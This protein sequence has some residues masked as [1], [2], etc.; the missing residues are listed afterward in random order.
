[1]IDAR[2]KDITAA[3]NRMLDSL[4]VDK[5]YEV[6]S[7]LCVRPTILTRHSSV[8][9]KLTRD[10]RYKATGDMF[11]AL[12]CHPPPGALRRML[13]IA[14]AQID[15]FIADRRDRREGNEDE[16]EDERP[17]DE[18]AY[19][20]QLD[21]DENQIMGQMRATFKY[22]NR[23]TLD[24]ESHEFIESVLFAIESTVGMSPEIMELEQDTE[25]EYPES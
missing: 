20:R 25:E 2:T 17:V 16:D 10:A 7:I 11:R 1:M 12:Q 8:T 23:L 24:N 6:S 21:E 19:A 18:R 5:K 14:D 4:N 15:Q 3:F 9:C 22:F 13:M